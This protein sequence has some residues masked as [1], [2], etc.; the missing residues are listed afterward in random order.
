M[1]QI[2]K[3]LKGYKACNTITVENFDAPVSTMN[4]SSRQKINEETLDLNN[5]LGQINLIDI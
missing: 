2:L 1:K 3:D 4:R 5:T